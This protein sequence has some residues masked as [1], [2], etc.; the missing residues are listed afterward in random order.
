MIWAIEHRQPLMFSWPRCRPESAGPPVERR[1]RGGYGGSR[2]RGS[3]E[4]WTSGNE[5]R[6]SGGFSGSRNEPPADLEW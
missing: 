2:G 4:G 5:G 3:S 1:S 6:S